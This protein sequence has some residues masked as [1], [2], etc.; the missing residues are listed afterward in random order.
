MTTC[1]ITHETL[2]KFKRICKY[3]CKGLL[4]Y[5]DRYPASP[6][7]LKLFSFISL[8]TLYSVFSS[9]IHGRHPQ[10]QCHSLRQQ[11][12]RMHHEFLCFLSFILQR[13]M[14]GSCMCKHENKRCVVCRKK[15]C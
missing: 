7:T 8:T 2:L 9:M 15:V 14:Q 5:R 6:H 13:K 4:N 11:Q 12:L 3:A 1:Y 10:P